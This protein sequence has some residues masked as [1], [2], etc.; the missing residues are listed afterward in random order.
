MNSRTA[1]PSGSV[2]LRRAPL[3]DGGYE[4]RSHYGGPEKAS[5]MLKK[6]PPQQL[7]GFLAKYDPAVAAVARGTLAR[8]R[9][10]LRG[11]TEIVYDNYNALAIGF[12]PGERASEAI[13]SIAVYPRWV[14]LFFL[15]GARLED[16]A[17]LLKGKGAR[18]RH[19]VLGEARD[20][21]SADVDA[22]ISAA[23]KAAA[24]PIDPKA[25]RQLIIK[26]IS[27]KQRPRRPQLKII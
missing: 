3:H 1:V 5:R 18:V 15:Q 2:P 20:I 13:I 26:S 27:A 21:D 25:K 23:L 10:R 14:S 17:K 6:T 19:I 12:G 8:L 22:L 24:R 9:K 16:P 4:H 7:A 11:A